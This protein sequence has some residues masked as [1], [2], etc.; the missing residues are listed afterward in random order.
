MLLERSGKLAARI[1]EYEKLKG[2]ASETEQ[3]NTRANQLDSISERI[4]R[5]REQLAGF[6]RAGV[7]VSFVP[8]D[9]R[10]Y[11][12]KAKDLRTAI[13]NNPANVINP[14]I[15]LKNEFA[16]RLVG[17]AAAADK[18]IA[19]AWRTFVAARANFRSRDILIALSAV[20]QFR[21][22]VSRIRQCQ[23]NIEALG[24][25]LPADPRTAVER[26]HA[27]ITDHDN[28]WAELSTE[29]IPPGVISFIRAAAAEGAMLSA[30]SQEVEAW[31]TSRSLLG[32][33]RIKFG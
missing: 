20:P 26:L 14:P 27:L 24:S 15:D 32:A 30:Y 12:A 17:I 9:A 22:S 23:T 4:S 3:F 29:D 5:T 11:A 25:T 33:F 2:M 21:S 28:A 16:D 10:G 1:A 31:I 19:E 6:A 18:C 8:S 7:P 13:H